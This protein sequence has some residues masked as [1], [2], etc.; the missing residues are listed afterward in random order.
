MA[1]GYAFFVPSEAGSQLPRTAITLPLLR[2]SNA[3][4][5]TRCGTI[6]A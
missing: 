6:H 5:P 4:N 1:T 3:L 2:P